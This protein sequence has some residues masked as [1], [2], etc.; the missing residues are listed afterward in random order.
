M[1][2]VPNRLLFLLE[3][4]VLLVVPQLVLF[5]QIIVDDRRLHRLFILFVVRLC[6]ENLTDRL[7]QFLN[8]VLVHFKYSN[9]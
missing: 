7:W 1:L 6:L 9:L 4:I 2:Q 8:I 5:N 3:N